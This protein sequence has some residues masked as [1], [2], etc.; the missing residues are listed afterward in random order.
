MKSGYFWF[1]LSSSH[2]TETDFVEI[3]AFNRSF[4]KILDEL[5]QN[6]TIFSSSFIKT[7]R[8]M[9]IVLPI[10]SNLALSGLERLLLVQCSNMLFW[11][12]I[13]LLVTIGQSADEKIENSCFAK[14]YS[15]SV[16]T[17]K[18]AVYFKQPLNNLFVLSHISYCENNS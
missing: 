14:S 6:K 11:L 12:R 8:R 5:I 16:S 1:W 2:P 9:I 13:L 4:V 15:R 3:F 10:V 7:S 17:T 18:V